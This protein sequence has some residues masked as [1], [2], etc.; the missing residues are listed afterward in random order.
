MGA[1]QKYETHESQAVEAKERDRD[2]QKGENHFTGRWKEQ[3]FG[4]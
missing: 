3:M 4:K 2:L 1:P